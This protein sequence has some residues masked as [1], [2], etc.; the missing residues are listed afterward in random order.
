MIS[1]TSKRF[2][3]V[4]QGGLGNRMRVIRS[5]YELARSG[6]GDVHVA[7]ARNNE[8]YCRFEDVFGE[9]NPPLQNFR[10]ALAKWIDAPSSIRNLHLPGA[11][12]TLYYDLQLNGFASFHREKIMTFSA[13]ARKVYIAT[14]YEFFDTKLEM[15]SLFTPSAAVKT[16]VESAT[17]RFEGRVVGF[18]IRATDNAPALKQSPYTLFEQT[19]RKEL[20]SYPETVFFLATDNPEVKRRFL[21]AFGKRVVTSAGELSRSSVGGM[22]AAAADMFALSRC[23]VIYG[24]HYS[25]FSEIAAELGGKQVKV[26]RL[27]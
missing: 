4:P 13:H 21:A 23:N 18:H 7:F 11:V 14:C 2:V 16:A 8:C 20:E 26:L 19:A 24:S 1:P 9:I 27:S 25:S 3:V 5:A 10:I 6:Y 17:R 12:R 22:V 15:S